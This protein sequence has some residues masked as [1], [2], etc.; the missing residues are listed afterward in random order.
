MTHYKYG[1]LDMNNVDELAVEFAC[2]GTPMPLNRDEITVAAQRMI[3]KCSS[4]EIARRCCTLDRTIVRILSAL[5]AQQCPHCRQ[6][7]IIDDAGV[8]S[9]HVDYWWGD[10]CSQSYR[11]MQQRQKVAS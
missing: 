6:L 1:D 9:K 7:V 8:V 2:Q 5:G 10:L 11:P 3:G 4:T